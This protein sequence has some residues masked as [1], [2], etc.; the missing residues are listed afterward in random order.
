ME[1]N[2]GPEPVQAL[3]CNDLQPNLTCYSNGENEKS[4]QLGRNGSEQA[5]STGY[6]DYL[7]DMANLLV[8]ISNSSGPSTA[9]KCSSFFNSQT[10]AITSSKTGSR[11]SPRVLLY[12]FTGI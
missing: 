11:T 5:G 9:E 3:N 10:L 6:I 2:N 12:F 1:W 7:Y 4:A 8:L